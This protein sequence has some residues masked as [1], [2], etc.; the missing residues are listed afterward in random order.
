MTSCARS[1]HPPGGGSPPRFPAS[2]TRDAFS[3]LRLQITVFVLDRLLTFVVLGPQLPAFVFGI[4]LGCLHLLHVE[5]GLDG[6]APL[7]WHV[8]YPTA[9]AH[10]GGLSA[11]TVAVGLIVALTPTTALSSFMIAW[12]R[13]GMLLPFF[14]IGLLGV[15]GGRDPLCALLSSVARPLAPAFE[16]LWQPMLLCAHPLW[17]L[18]AATTT[19]AEGAL[20][21]FA[22]MLPCV[23]AAIDLL[24]RRPCEGPMR[25]LLDGALGAV[26][27]AD[28]GSSAWERLIMYYGGMA[29]VFGFFLS[30]SIGS[31][32][33]WVVLADLSGAPDALQGFL[34]YTSWLLAVPLLALGMGLVGQVLYPCVVRPDA[35]PVKQQLAKLAKADADADAA[36]DPAPIAPSDVKLYWR[37]VTRGLSPDLVAANVHSAFA[38]LKESGLPRERWEVEVVCDNAMGLPE[39]TGTEVLEVVV[40]SDYKCPNGGKFKARALHWGAL[41][42]SSARRHD[43]I[44]HMDEETRFDVDTVSATRDRG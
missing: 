14:G 16:I 8:R 35:V 19:T 27:L 24:I 30:S 9:W 11:A 21:A 25:G 18:A 23:A 29:G 20:A 6:G 7:P 34:Y 32:S 40:P 31:D 44:I 41:H 22:L 3:V 43:W 5:A 15:A 39:R 26:R 37:V 17:Y 10:R 13:A 4:L 36:G 33:Q 38:V 42:G 2:L 12:G 1:P 28:K